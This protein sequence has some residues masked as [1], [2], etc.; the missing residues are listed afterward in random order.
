MNR[1][2]DLQKIQILNDWYQAYFNIVGSVIAGGFIGLVVLFTTLFYGN[3]LMLSMIFLILWVGFAIF[4]KR[5]L[6]KNYDAFLTY[7]DTLHRKVERGEALPSIM[8]LRK[9]PVKQNIV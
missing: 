4:G 8:E 2:V 9:K 6:D 3:L 5:F 1:D 7:I